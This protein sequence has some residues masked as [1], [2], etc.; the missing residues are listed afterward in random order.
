MFSTEYRKEMD[1]IMLSGKQKQAIA[2][3]MTSARVR[4]ARRLPR[5]FAAAAVVCAMVAAT[6]AAYCMGAFEFLK[7]R[8][9]H[10]YLGMNE[11]YETYA[12]KVGK[13]VTAENGDVVTVDRV[14][15]DRTFCTIFY[16]V[17]FRE[18][19]VTQEELER[20]QAERR[21]D[22]FQTI[23]Y[24]PGFYLYSGEEEISQEGYNNSFEPQ[25]YLADTHTVYGAWRFL[26]RHPLADGETVQ[27]RGGDYERDDNGGWKLVWEFSLDFTARPIQSE[28]FDSDVTFTA[29]IQGQDVQV[30]VISLER[31][32]LGALLTLC[33]EKVEGHDAFGADFVLRDG[34]SGTYIPFSEVWVNHHWDPEGYCVDIYELFGDVSMLK[35]L[36]LIPTCDAGPASPRKTVAVDELPCEDP[37]NPDGGYVPISY[38]A[39]GGQIMIEMKPVGAT[40]NSFSRIIN[41]L[42]PHLMDAEGN[43]LFDDVRVEQYK[44]RSDGAITVVMTPSAESY[45]RDADKVTQFWFFVQRYDVL[46]GQTVHI[47]LE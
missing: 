36:E 43:D 10:A 45:V 44:D 37:G 20:L 5:A 42:T 47:P 13:S 16:S 6:A 28:R 41:A 12:Q 30:D 3:A 18:P 19:V 32:P 1:Q 31:S 4:R 21:D 35:N 39:E 23:A 2:A 46:E 7:E 22:G 25:A 9:E 17:R 38:T 11:I 8:D 34:D 26:L 29:M 33:R 27:L 40:N 15:M 24:M 14:V